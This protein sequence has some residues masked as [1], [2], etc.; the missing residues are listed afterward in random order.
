MLVAVACVPR[1]GKGDQSH[2]PDKEM[3][4]SFFFRMFVL[5]YLTIYDRM[6]TEKINSRRHR[7]G[8]CS[9]SL[10]SPTSCTPPAQV[11]AQALEEKPP[12][13]KPFR[14]NPS[15]LR[16]VTL[17]ATCC[18]AMIVNVGLSLSL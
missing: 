17:I 8:P 4:I 3:G 18:G 16:S 12:L 5:V 14:L 6:D 15:F 7:T 9:L 1:A 10:S 13:V 11:M 2:G